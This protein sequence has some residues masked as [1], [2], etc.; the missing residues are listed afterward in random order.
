MLL[1][2]LDP[3]SG[4]WFLNWGRNLAFP[5]ETTYHAV[6][7]VAWLATLR[8]HWSLAALM[9]ALAAA[10]HP[11]TG[12][13]LLATM[14]AWWGLRLILVPG[15]E[16]LRYAAVT[17]LTVTCF[18]TYYFVYLN[19]FPS[20]TRLSEVWA[21]DWSL[22]SRTLAVAY[23]P[24]FVLAAA[25]LW[26]DRK[27]LS[28]KE[29]FLVVCF[30]A[31]AALALHDRVL[32]PVQ[33]LH[34]TR[35]YI[36]TPLFL[37]GLP[38]M[39]D[40]LSWLRRRWSRPAFFAALAVFVVLGV[41]DNL[42]FFVR[43]AS[44]PSGQGFTLTAE[45][46][47]ALRSI[48]RECLSGV[49]AC[50][51]NDLCYLTATYTG[52]TPYH[53]QPFVSPDGAAHTKQVKAWLAGHED[54]PWIERMNYLLLRRATRPPL[55]KPYEWRRVLERST[56]PMGTRESTLNSV[57]RPQRFVRA[58]ALLQPT[59]VPPKH[60]PGQTSD[61]DQAVVRLVDPMPRTLHRTE[62]LARLAI[63]L[64]DP[65]GQRIVGEILD[66]VAVGDD[67]HFVVRSNEDILRR[68]EMIPLAQILPVGSENLNTIVLA[69]AH[70]DG[71]R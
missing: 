54:G 13:E 33:P 68:S 61:K 51:D 1:F 17:A 56:H 18:L 15:R 50:E 37:I 57:R 19:S 28:E 20:H 25:R 53:G 7:A 31:A 23:G 16:S 32:P 65:T 69:I 9:T 22:R 11:W 26:R 10:T 52:L 38:L 58:K 71:S 46:R 21:L 14:S 62:D 45:E 48:D 34:F 66:V 2:R 60:I 44:L 4:W 42:A 40:G 30:L 27:N 5:T 6:V 24:V 36:W 63:D 12:L 41:S 70:V 29:G 64:H 59:R 67:P 55:M 47:G 35:G 49:V 39:G 43:E 3:A 8:K